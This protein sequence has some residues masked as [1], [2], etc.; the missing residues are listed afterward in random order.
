MKLRYKLL[1]GYLVIIVLALILCLLAL[2]GYRTVYT[3]LVTITEDILPGY[4]AMTSMKLSALTMVVEAR[5]YL[6]TDDEMH[7]Q[8][9]RE[10]MGILRESLRAHLEH[11][12]HIGDEEKGAAENM[13]R[14]G[15]RLIDLCNSLIDSH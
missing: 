5:D 7:V 14:K 2:N 11:E 12:A 9:A 3:H 8:Y 15:L 4:Q 1:G 13:E 10:N 6:R